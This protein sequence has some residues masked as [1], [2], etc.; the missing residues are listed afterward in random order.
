VRFHGARGRREDDGVDE[1]P[2]GSSGLG[3]RVGILERLR[4]VG[5][6]LPVQLRHSRMQELRRLVG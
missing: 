3:P 4:K 6:L 1:A 2:N 5:H